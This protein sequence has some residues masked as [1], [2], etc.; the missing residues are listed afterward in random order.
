MNERQKLE[1]MLT[2][3]GGWLGICAAILIARWL[4]F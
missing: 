3:W 4:F 1:G 2:E